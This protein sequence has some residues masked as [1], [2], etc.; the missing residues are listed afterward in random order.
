MDYAAAVGYGVMAMG[1]A[2]GDAA[3]V[4]AVA[5]KPLDIMGSTR[6][7]ANTLTTDLR[8]LL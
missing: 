4:E 6:L 5:G 1:A 3:F 8:R 2:V 7:L